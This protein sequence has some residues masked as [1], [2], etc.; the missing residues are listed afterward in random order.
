MHRSSTANPPQVHAAHVDTPVETRRS[1]SPARLLAIGGIT[2][3]VVML[4]LL[5]GYGA[6]HEGR[7]FRGVSV[8]GKDLGGM[9]NDETRAALAGASANYPSGS[10]TVS[11]AG[12]TWT[13]APADL[14]WAVD[15]NKTAGTA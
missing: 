8:L 6:V 11:G 7:V 4:A 1:V 2:V 3:L 13:F 10:I 9:S 12:R 15:L 14:G 5:F